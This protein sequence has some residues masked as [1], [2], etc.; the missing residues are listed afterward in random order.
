MDTLMLRRRAMMLNA[1]NSVTNPECVFTPNK[2]LI[3]NAS[4]ETDWSGVGITAYLPVVRNDT[5][6]YSNPVPSP[7]VQTS[8][9]G[10][11]GFLQVTNDAY[12]QTDW[13]N[14]RC[15]GSER[16]I[17]CNTGGTSMSGYVRLN[18]IMDG[19]A[20]SYAYNA[21]TGKVYYA[22]KNTPYYGKTNIND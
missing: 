3:R 1:K 16:S 6:K 10:I 8:G 15:D 12:T 2:A 20:D 11:I 4:G 18:I 19:L 7:N 9:V 22:G 21:T 5:F 14:C 17:A 13:W